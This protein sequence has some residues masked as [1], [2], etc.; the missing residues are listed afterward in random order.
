MSDQSAEQQEPSME[1]ILASIRRIISDEDEEGECQDVAAEADPEP[2]LEPEPEEDVLV[3]TEVV[4]ET[5]EVVQLMDPQPDV[6]PI[7]SEAPAAQA[8]S[9]V[10]G[11]VAAIN[12]TMPVGDL[13]LAALI[14]ELLRPLLKE[15]LDQNLPPI[16]ETIVR[17]EIERVVYKRQ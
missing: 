17:D 10:A 12:A 6:E 1:E 16:V 14:K 8:T 15:W 7:I 5:A 11:L 3:L 9:S 13:T 2:E 4:E